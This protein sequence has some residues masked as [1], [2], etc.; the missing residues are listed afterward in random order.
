MSSIIVRILQDQL[1]SACLPCIYEWLHPTPLPIQI[2]KFHTYINRSFNVNSEYRVASRTL[3]I[4][5]C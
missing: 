4:H 1:D 2:R 3:F 5:G